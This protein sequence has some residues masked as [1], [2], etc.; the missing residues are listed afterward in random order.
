MYSENRKP[1]LKGLLGKNCNCS[2]VSKTWLSHKR[3]RHSIDTISDY[4]PVTIQQ[5]HNPQK[6]GYRST[7]GMAMTASTVTAAIFGCYCP[8]ELHS[9][10]AYAWLKARL[11]LLYLIKFG[12]LET[13][14]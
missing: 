7:C 12:K 14:I 4:Y 11:R 2:R 1:V 6:K 8:P 10:S 13:I 3:Y 5:Q 9:T